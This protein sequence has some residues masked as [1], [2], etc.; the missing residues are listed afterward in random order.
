M[1]VTN[2]SVYDSVRYNL[3]KISEDMSKANKIVSS[4]KLISNLS[5]DPVGLTQ[6][7]KIKSVIA[8]IDQLG[9]NVSL[10]KSWLTASESALTSVQDLISD[11]KA[12]CIQMATATTG[13]PQRASAARTVQNILDEIISLSNTEVSG[14]YIF[15]G[16]KTDSLAFDQS[17]T[18]LGNDEPFAVKIGMDTTAS[19]GRNGQEVF[20]AIFTVL[21]DLKDK[22]NANNTQGI[23]TSLDGLTDNFN[24]ITNTISDIGSKMNRMEI[25]EQIFQDLKLVNTD[26][27][28][29]IEDA[30]IADAI[31]N[32]KEKEL[33][34]QAALNSSSKVMQLSLAD[35][36]K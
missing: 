26:R 28:S 12:L 30:D 17:G 8:G 19:V 31:I 2:N 27:L 18:Y 20:G 7:L 33:A 11:T 9:R 3:G 36:L 4:G 10:G 13:A 35:Y 5:D 34:Y 29:A 22:L 24:N 15:S 16:T 23:L 25:K 1:R 21:S 6:S 14:R 32:I